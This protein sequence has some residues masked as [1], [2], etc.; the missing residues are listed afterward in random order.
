MTKIPDINNFKEEGFVLA[1]HFQ[2]FQSIVSGFIESGLQVRHAGASG[3]SSSPSGRQEVKRE[4]LLPA[5]TAFL[6]FPLLFQ[7]PQPVRMVTSI[8]KVGLHLLYNP[9][10]KCLPG[11]T[12]MCFTDLLGA[13]QFNQVANQD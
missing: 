11:Y 7:D 4:Y 6:L 12:Q 2:R 1:S 10:W 13:S 9:L 5:L 3:R 8:L